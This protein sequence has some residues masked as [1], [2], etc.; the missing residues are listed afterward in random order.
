M[1]GLLSAVGFLTIL[2]GGKRTAFDP[3]A[4]MPFFPVVGLILGG[5]VALFDRIALGLWPGPVAALLDTLLLVVLTGALHL[6]GLGD[7]A[8]GLFSHRPR[9]QALEI[10]KDSRIGVMGL[11]AV[12]FALALKWAGLSALEVHRSLLLI[13]VPAYARAGMLFAIRCLPY[14]RPEGGTGR[15]FFGT[16]LNWRDFWAVFTLVLLS[17]VMGAVALRLLAGFAAITAGLI[18]FYRKRMGCVTGDMLGAMSET[19]EAGLFLLAA[20]GAGA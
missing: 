15:D 14:G 7:T 1:K 9:E 19:I 20:A 6:D 4:M 3:A 11:V 5:V 18:L 17:L 10:M 16:A 13:L 8:D 2:S 12:V